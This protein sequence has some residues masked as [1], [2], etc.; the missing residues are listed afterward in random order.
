HWNSE[1]GN[2]L[3][4]FVKQN[5]VLIFERFYSADAAADE[6]AKTVR[7]FASHLEGGIGHRH[8]RRRHGQLGKAISPPNIFRVLEDRFRIEA[9][10]F[11][12]DAA[13][14]GRSVEGFDFM[15]AADA[16]LQVRPKSLEIVAEG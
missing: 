8:F 12:T 4:T 2:A 11:S 5:G 15:N 14:I 10:H 16:V 6:N 7:I 13:I 1:S 9:V 3:W